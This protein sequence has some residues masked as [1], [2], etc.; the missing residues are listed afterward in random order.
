LGDSVGSLYI[1]TGYH[2][3]FIS[4]CCSLHPAALTDSASVRDALADPNWRRAMGEEYGALLS[5]NTWELVQQPPNY[6][7]ITGKWIFRHK[8]NADGS[9]ERYKA[10]WVLCGFTR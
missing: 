10:C 8:F 5:N 3:F 4:G 2:I 6:N 7:I 9:L 1:I